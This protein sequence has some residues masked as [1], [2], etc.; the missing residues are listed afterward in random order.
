M[1]GRL[2]EYKRTFEQLDLSAG[3]DITRA[4]E[5]LDPY[6]PDVTLIKTAEARVVVERL[7]GTVDQMKLLNAQ[8]KELEEALK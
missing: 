6:E 2:A 1:R 5:L 7:H 8:I 4:R 3:S